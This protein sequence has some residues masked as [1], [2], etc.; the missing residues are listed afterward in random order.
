M[1]S[2]TADPESSPAAPLAPAGWDPAAGAEPASYAEATAEL[3]RLLAGLERDP[4]D[5]DVLVADVRRATALLR[6][7]RGRLHHA[8]VEVT[9]VI[10]ELDAAAD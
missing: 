8:R 6:W 9:E 1:A 4:A 10:A 7:C 2:M 5:V 3:D